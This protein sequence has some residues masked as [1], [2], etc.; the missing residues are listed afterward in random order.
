MINEIK[1]EF[2]SIQ[3]KCNLLSIAR[4][5]VYQERKRD[6]IA[7]R[8][9][10][11]NIQ[12]IKKIDKIYMRC[13]FYGSRRIR[14]QLNGE[15]IHVNRKRVQRLMREMGIMGVAPGIM[16]SK[17]HPE[18]KVY[19]Y[20]L[21]GVSIERSNQVWS[22]DITYIPTP[23]GLM[24]LTAIVDWYSR[25]ILSWE[26]SN[27]MDDVFCVRAL[28]RALRLYGTPEIFNTDQ[29]SQFTSKG[30]TGT[31]IEAGVQIS[32]DSR[33]RAF[34]NIF[35]ERF[36]R[37]VK[38]EWLYI[39]EYDSVEALKSGLEAYMRYYNQERPHQSLGYRKPDEVYQELN[40]KG[41]TVA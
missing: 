8:E 38:Y 9:S 25:K 34:D 14:V 11:E 27:T 22:C 24:Y 5:S 21:K 6:I 1:E 37:N 40:K 23:N 41:E 36:W 18:H 29:G 15:G 35:I 10:P 2:L 20:L 12:I 31:L 19:P 4:S 16:T 26:L 39:H 32:M 7:Q 13:P 30:F 28:D 33:G 3:E 17:P